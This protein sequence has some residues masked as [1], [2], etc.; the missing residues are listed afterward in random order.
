MIHDKIK[1][2]LQKDKHPFLWTALLLICVMSLMLPSCSGDD[3]KMNPSKSGIHLKLQTRADDNALSGE[4][5]ISSIRMMIYDEMNNL[6]INYLFQGNDLK[7]TSDGYIME[8]S[9]DNIES[10]YKTFCLIA[11]ETSSL[12]PALSDND[13]IKTLEELQNNDLKWEEHPSAIKIDNLPFTSIQRKHLVSGENNVQ[14][15]LKRAVGRIDLSICKDESLSNTE[16]V[17][18]SVQVINTV[19]NSDLFGNNP[20]IFSKNDLLSL[21]KKTD[22]PNAGKVPDVVEKYLSITGIAY[23]YEHQSINVDE[24]TTLKVIVNI[25]GVEVEGIY[26]LRGDDN[27]YAIR[28][29]T[30][31]RLKLTT[32]RE[33]LVFEWESGD[34]N[35]EN[36]N[37]DFEED[38]G[39][40]GGEIDPGG[41]WSSEDEEVNFGD[42][43]DNWNEEDID[44]EFD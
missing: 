18:K 34:W 38:D 24:A 33:K 5:K 14:L 44:I 42:S 30:I 20:L 10:G 13:K 17:L 19:P 37:I 2:T 28:R 3:D 36:I 41:E 32:Y 26:P 6:E 16:V 27:L 15:S 29:N 11:N 8:K 40:I 35:E 31:N 22:F 12:S 7:S 1:T 43:D 39:I 21:D 9:L 4:Q 23:L 25:G